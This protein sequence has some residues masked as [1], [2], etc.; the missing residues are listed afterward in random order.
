M[1]A[2]ECLKEVIG[3]GSIHVGSDD[4]EWPWKVG[5]ERSNFQTDLLTN[6]NTVLTKNNEI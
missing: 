6:T 5:R 1:V 2:M 3:G 4:F